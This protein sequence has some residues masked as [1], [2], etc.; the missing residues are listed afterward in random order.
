MLIEDDKV[1]K[2]FATHILLADRIFFDTLLGC[3]FDNVLVEQFLRIP[4]WAVLAIIIDG[5][6]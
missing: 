5:K 4:G 3:P 6:P 1:K 2:Q